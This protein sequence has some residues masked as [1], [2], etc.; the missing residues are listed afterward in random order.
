VKYGNY[1]RNNADS[2]AMRKITSEMYA[3]KAKYKGE[4]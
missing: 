4:F 3:E 1:S 2:K